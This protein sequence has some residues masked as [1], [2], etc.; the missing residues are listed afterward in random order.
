MQIRNESYLAG[1]HD[2]GTATIQVEL[3]NLYT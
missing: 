1:L 3:S 2:K